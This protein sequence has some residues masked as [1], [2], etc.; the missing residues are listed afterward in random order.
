MGFNG[1]ILVLIMGLVRMI[2][3]GKGSISWLGSW[4]LLRTIRPIGGLS[5]LLGTQRVSPTL[6]F[7]IS[8]FAPV[9]TNDRPPINGLTALPHVLSILRNPPLHPRI[10]TKTILPNVSKIMRPRSRRTIQYRQLRPFNT[11]D[12]LHDRYRTT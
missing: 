8:S 5:C 9:K 1:D 11:H 10:K 3:L 12:S 2:I 6:L 7:I 4:I